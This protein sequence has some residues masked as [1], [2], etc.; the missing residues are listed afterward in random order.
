[1]AILRAWRAH[2]GARAACGAAAAASTPTS[3]APLIRFGLRPRAQFRYISLQR[4]HPTCKL[5]RARERGVRTSPS[6]IRSARTVAPTVIIYG[7]GIMVGD[8]SIFVTSAPTL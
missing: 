8:N 2:T 1:M 4:K 6:Y 5:A 3:V 7:V